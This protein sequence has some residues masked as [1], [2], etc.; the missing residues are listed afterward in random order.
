LGARFSSE[1]ELAARMDDLVDPR[2]W[3]PVRYPS[4]S[5]IEG[6]VA[7]GVDFLDRTDELLEE[8][9]EDL[10]QQAKGQTRQH[11]LLRGPRGIGKTHLAGVIYHRV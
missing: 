2:M 8:L 7:Q 3:E 4:A 5:R 6:S 9:L 1:G 10:R 11:W